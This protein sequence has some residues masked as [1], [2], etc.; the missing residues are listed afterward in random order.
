M[1][2]PPPVAWT[3]FSALT[4]QPVF[5]HRAPDDPNVAGWE[6]LYSAEQVQAAVLAE[7]AECA[8][9]CESQVGAYTPMELL[10]SDIPWEA[11][12][13]GEL[14]MADACAAAIRARGE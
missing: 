5:D 9:L 7:R 10:T 4:A 3:T 11:E 13:I 8:A 14:R 1:T 2:L 6:P 12:T